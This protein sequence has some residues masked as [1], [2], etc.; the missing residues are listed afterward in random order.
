MVYDIGATHRQPQCD[1][2]LSG[3][4]D[5]ASS[6]C[7]LKDKAVSLSLVMISYY[8]DLQMAT[9]VLSKDFS[10]A[11]HKRDGFSIAKMPSSISGVM[12]EEQQISGRVETHRQE[13]EAVPKLM[14]DNLLNRRS[15]YG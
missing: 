8:R 3:C 11:L 13:I 5:K 7:H 14:K 2:D 4:K 12:D 6:T 1:E 9:W 15:T 10:H